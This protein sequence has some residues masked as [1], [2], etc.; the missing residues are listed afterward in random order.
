M[1]P[2]YQEPPIP[3]K[4]RLRGFCGERSLVISSDVKSLAGLGLAKLDSKCYFWLFMGLIP[5]T[6]D[7]LLSRDF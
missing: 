1:I 6:W 2:R 7:I 3:A 4:H 5:S